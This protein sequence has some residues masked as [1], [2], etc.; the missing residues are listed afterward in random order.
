[1]GIAALIKTRLD[2]A[3]DAYLS[4]EEALW[5]NEKPDSA[6]ALFDS[7]SSH[8]G[9]TPYGPQAGYTSAWVHNELLFDSA[10][11]QARYESVYKKWKDTDYGRSAGRKVKTLIGAP[12][13]EAPPPNAQTRSANDTSMVKPGPQMNRQPYNRSHRPRPY[14]QQEQ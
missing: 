9:D 7:L 10:G 14:G 6:A 2:S 3:G 13:D 4:A 12:V 11:A 8:Y 1:L 5:K